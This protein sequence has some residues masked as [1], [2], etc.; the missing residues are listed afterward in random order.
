MASQITGVSIVY[1]TICSG[2]DKKKQTSKLRIT[3]LC[4]HPNKTHGATRIRD[5]SI[6]SCLHLQRGIRHFASLSFECKMLSYTQRCYMITNKIFYDMLFHGN[7]PSYEWLYT[8]VIKSTYVHVY[9]STFY[10]YWFTCYVQEH[11][12]ALTVSTNLTLAWIM[13]YRMTVA[14][15]SSKSVLIY[16]QFV[17]FLYQNPCRFMVGMLLLS[18]RVRD[19]RP[20]APF[21][22]MV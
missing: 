5:T 17:I 15:S 9:K 14:Q 22:N 11:L 13:A 21:T 16:C 8:C 19:Y 20:V 18:V 1:L 6:E 3:C 12:H 4:V 10:L 7:L 2:A